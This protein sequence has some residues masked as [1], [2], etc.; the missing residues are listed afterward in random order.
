MYYII[1]DSEKCW[2][3]FI[4]RDLCWDLRFLVDS[5]EKLR[6]HLKMDWLWFLIFRCMVGIFLFL[7]VVV[8][9]ILRCCCMW[10]FFGLCVLDDCVL[11]IV[12]DIETMW[13]MLWLFVS[14]LCFRIQYDFCGIEDKNC[15]GPHFQGLYGLGGRCK[16]VER[17]WVGWRTWLITV[18]Y[19]CVFDM[20]IVCVTLVWFDIVVNCNEK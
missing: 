19:K 18:R 4:E 6:F 20:C 8:R 2:L 3:V 15:L 16:L 1:I 17:I 9:G 7:G 10:D 14:V 11:R 13:K 12:P 5:V